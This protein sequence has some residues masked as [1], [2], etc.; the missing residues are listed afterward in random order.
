MPPQLNKQKDAVCE[1]NPK[2]SALSLPRAR[3]KTLQVLLHKRKFLILLVLQHQTVI[4]CK[5][6]FFLKLISLF[7]C[8]RPRNNFIYGVQD[9][10][11]ADCICGRLLLFSANSP[12]PPP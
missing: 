4:Y 3:I 1:R 9:N 5:D 2:K 7:Q 11:R 12:P 10:K 8:L 6:Y